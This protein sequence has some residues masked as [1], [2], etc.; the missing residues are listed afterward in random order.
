M[1]NVYTNPTPLTSSIGLITSVIISVNPKAALREIQ[2]GDG[3]CE[4]Q[5]L[6][7][8]L[9]ECRSKLI[10]QPNDLNS[11]G[12]ADFHASVIESAI[13]AIRFL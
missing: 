1:A 11:I 9:G 8:F 5:I 12:G 10:R 7:E 6:F 2:K 4:T 3:N 13:T